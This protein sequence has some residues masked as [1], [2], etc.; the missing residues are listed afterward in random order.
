[1]FP[2]CFCLS[3]F[4]PHRECDRSEDE[5]LCD[6]FWTCVGH[7]HGECFS[8]PPPV[9]NH[10]RESSDTRRSS[11]LV[12]LVRLIKKKKKEKCTG[13]GLS[14][15]DGWQISFLFSICRTIRFLF[16]GRIANIWCLLSLIFPVL[17]LQK[18][19]CVFRSRQSNVL[20]LKGFFFCL[21]FAGTLQEKKAGVRDLQ[22]EYFLQSVAASAV[23][24]N[25]VESLYCQWQGCLESLFPKKKYLRAKV[26]HN[27]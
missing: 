15:S 11:I 1:M 21:I 14:I 12:V 8:S 2:L 4:F 26:S 19:W 7:R 22:S 18:P 23:S 10:Q 5:H 20:L 16:S 25:D 24:C 17:Y 9:F 3:V 13:G 6:K 27:T